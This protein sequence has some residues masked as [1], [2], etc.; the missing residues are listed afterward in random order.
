MSSSGYHRGPDRGCFFS[1]LTEARSAAAAE[2]C[3]SPG[4]A[5]EK[6]EG[7]GEQGKPRGAGAATDSVHNPPSALL[8]FVLA[9]A[10]GGATSTVRSIEMMHQPRLRHECFLQPS[11]AGI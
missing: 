5:E 3:H 1:S 6:L 10:Q 11:G 2:E 8:S 7:G 4:E 9:T